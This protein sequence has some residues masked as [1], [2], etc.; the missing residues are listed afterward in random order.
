M[1]RYL[2]KIIKLRLKFGNKI[3]KITQATNKIIK[4]IDNNYV[5][6]IFDRKFIINYVFFVNQGLII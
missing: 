6:N 4:Y 2:K 1:F 5:N 3:I